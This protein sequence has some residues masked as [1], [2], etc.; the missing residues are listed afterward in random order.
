MKI[1]LDDFVYSKTYDN[2]SRLYC[3]NCKDKDIDTSNYDDYE[4]DVCECCSD[5]DFYYNIY[6]EN[7][8][9][10]ICT[11]TQKNNKVLYKLNI[12]PEF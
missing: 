10:L 7:D 11:I 12:V 5:K 6:E 2:G 1:V 3:N 8:F 9:E 4:D